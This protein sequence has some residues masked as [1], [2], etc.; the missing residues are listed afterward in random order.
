MNETMRLL[1]IA[2]DEIVNAA[3]EFSDGSSIRKHLELALGAIES[4]KKMEV[5]RW[6]TP[7]QWKQRTGKPWP[8]N[9]AVYYRLIVKYIDGRDA[10]GPWLV[11][12]HSYLVSLD[13]ALM[14]HQKKD[15]CRYQQV[16]TTGAGQPPDDWIPDEEL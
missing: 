16:C 8:E 7:E 14:R 5:P 4:V 15:G 6:E 13:M 10:P 3:V 9:G 1:D 12:F 11:G 2:A